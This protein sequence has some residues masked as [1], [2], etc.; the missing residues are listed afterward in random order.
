G[1]P[2]GG[3]ASVTAGIVSS[4]AGM[5][6][7][8]GRISAVHADVRLAPGNSGG[9][10]VDASGAAVGINAMVAGGMGLAIPTE[11]VESFLAA[12]PAAQPTVIGVAAVPVPLPTPRGDEGTWE[13]VGLLVTD[14]LPGSAAEGAGLIPGD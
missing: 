14:V 11:A 6:A 5:A 12:G 3:G 4:T 7:E 10:L 9:P 8:G 1:H 2:W 13:G